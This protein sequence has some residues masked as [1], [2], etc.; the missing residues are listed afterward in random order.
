MPED[1]RRG[2]PPMH[3]MLSHPRLVPWGQRLGRPA[4]ASVAA[5][6]LAAARKRAQNGLQPPTIDALAASAEH[7]LEERAQPGFRRV[8][9]AT[10]VVLHTG[11]GRAPLAPEALEAIVHTAGWY[12][13]LE[14]DLETGRRGRR[15]ASLV[16]ALRELSGAEDALVVNNNAAAVLL[17]LSALAAG[18]EVIVSRGE[19]VEIGGA[20]RIPEVMVQGG[21]QLREIG[22]TNRTTLRDYQDALGPQTALI[23]KVHRSNFRQIGFTA[24]PSLSALSALARAHG[25]PLAFDLGSGT[26]LPRPDE[27]DIGGAIAA[28][29]D[30]V[31]YSGDKLLG[32][33][34]AG[35]LCGRSTIIAACA[36]H[37]LQR[38]LRIDKLTTAALEATLALYQGADAVERIPALSMLARDLPSLHRAASALHQALQEAV[39]GCDVRLLRTSSAAG[40]G[41]M[42]GQE[43]ATWAVAFR[44]PGQSATQLAAALRHGP[45]A[46]LARVRRQCIL[47]DPRTLL[48]GEL[49]LIPS[50]VAGACRTAEAR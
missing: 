23:L 36:R 44:C 49:A 25:V 19:L 48:P 24:E 16:A 4:V 31:T 33:P 9:N 35:I 12:S 37:P 8:V 47:L 32:G 11:L 38:A 39:P 6:V 13:N 5:A 28:G 41:A 14:W 50:L 15:S 10:G 18:R 22:T 21:A 17:L 7:L 26:V 43:L 3:A 42:A 40:G 34:Q 20:F 29:C 2:L 46:L 1:H 27:P 30:V 45:I